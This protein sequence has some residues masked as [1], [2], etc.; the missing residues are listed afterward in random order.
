M[1]TIQNTETQNY[2]NEYLEEIVEMVPRRILR[3]HNDEVSAGQHHARRR[4]RRHVDSP[5]HDVCQ[6]GQGS[7][8]LLDLGQGD[9]RVGLDELPRR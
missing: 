8:D 7:A 1:I 9:A 2:L 4:V 5:Q 3:Q 6:S